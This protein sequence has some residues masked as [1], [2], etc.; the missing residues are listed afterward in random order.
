MVD[1]RSIDTDPGMDRN[2]VPLTCVDGPH[3]STGHG[4]LVS[5]LEAA[6]RG[7]GS[8][9]ESDLS[10]KRRQLLSLQKPL[11]LQGREDCDSTDM[12]PVP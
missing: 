4:T 8:D 12:E 5:S 2:C 7:G 1:P 3:L 10:M 11:V 9:T 6:G